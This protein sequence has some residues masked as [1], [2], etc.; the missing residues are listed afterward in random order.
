M[1]CLKSNGGFNLLLWAFLYSYIAIVIWSIIYHYLRFSKESFFSFE[2]LFIPI[3]LTFPSIYSVFKSPI[4]LIYFSILGFFI[5]RLYN[6]KKL[7]KNIK[8]ILLTVIFI[9]WNLLGFYIFREV[10][11]AY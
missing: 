1:K 2:S 5:F 7:N 8:V 11:I 4:N 3:T 10:A 6:H 9:L